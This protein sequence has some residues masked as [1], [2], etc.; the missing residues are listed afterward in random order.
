MEVARLQGMT[1]DELVAHV[2]AHAGIG[3][4]EAARAV[5]AVLGTLGE[6]LSHSEAGALADALP[7]GAAARLRAGRFDR[8]FDLEELY[9]RV[10]RRAGV[11]LG[12]A[13]EHTIAV[14]ATVGERLD[15][16]TRAR[17]GRALPPEMLALFAVRPAVEAPPPPP[18]VGAHTT[19]AEGRPGSRRPLSESAP[20]PA[21]AD[22]VARADNPHG[23]TKL[24]SARGLT[25]ERE[26]EDLATGH[27]RPAR[28]IAG[29]HEE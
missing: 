14:C 29:R 10:A 3:A 5:A 16:A 13:V 24:S 25:Q 20:P 15:A 4:A 11:R 23:D 9:G 7:A 28:P 22:S 12:F 17:L 21:Q 26:H 6:R 2:A 27:P 18:R 19:L 1:D 8:D